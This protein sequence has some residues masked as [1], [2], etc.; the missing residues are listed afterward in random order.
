MEIH[1]LINVATRA[2]SSIIISGMGFCLEA[3]SGPYQELQDGHAALL[4]RRV[5]SAQ[6]RFPVFGSSVGQVSDVQRRHRM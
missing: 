2:R 5:A 4:L 3:A 1:Q 6:I